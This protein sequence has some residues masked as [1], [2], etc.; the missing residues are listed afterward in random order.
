MATY[1]VR[2]KANLSTCHIDLQEVFNRVVIGFDCA[3]LEGHREKATH[4]DYLHRGLT[5]VSYEESCHSSLPSN[6]IHAVPYP[7]DWEDR[8]RFHYFAGY[9]KGI[10]DMMGVKIRWG[11]N[12]KG[13]NDFKNNNFD[14]LCHYELEEE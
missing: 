2:S 4:D 3:I 1:S 6:A 11:G 9:V 7:I 10:A 14:D 12:W 13:D 5:Q 8:E